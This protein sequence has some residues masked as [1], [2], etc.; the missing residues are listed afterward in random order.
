MIKEK[1]TQST[2]SETQKIELENIMFTNLSSWGIRQSNARISKL[3]PIE[4]TLAPGHSILRSDGYHLTREEGDFLELKFAALEKAGIVKRQKNTVWGHPVFV[5]PK[6][7]Q[8]PSDWVNYSNDQREEWKQKNILNRYRISPGDPP[9]KCLERRWGGETPPALFC[10][11]IVTDIIDGQEE[12]F[13]AKPNN[14]CIAWFD[15]LLL[16]SETFESLLHILDAL[17]KQ[18]ARMSVRFNLR[19]CGL[20][21]PTT[22]WCG[23]QIKHGQWNF[24]PS[25]FDKILNL[26]KPKYQH[27]VA[28]LVYLCNW[29]APNVP[30]M[31]AL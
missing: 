17:L 25:F 21:E 14:G 12:K 3:H 23:R 26:P 16:Y 27:E 11:R 28:Q 18:A 19:K 30:K 13:F 31:A 9:G 7:M 5:V 2:L 29:I 1:C 10:E 8:T 4:V 6:K 22:I 15:D 20:C 24:D